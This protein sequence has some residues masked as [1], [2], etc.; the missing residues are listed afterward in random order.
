MGC[1][2]SAK[3]SFWSWSVFLPVASHISP[4]V[5]LAILIGLVWQRAFLMS[6][7]TVA[8]EL[9][10]IKRTTFLIRRMKRESA[11]H[12]N[13]LQDISRQTQTETNSKARFRMAVAALDDMINWVHSGGRV[14]IYD[15]TNS[16]E[17]RNTPLSR[18]FFIVSF[19]LFLR[20]NS[21][22]VF[23]RNEGSLCFRAAAK[24]GLK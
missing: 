1:S 14:A 10:H 16:T 20:D 4:R 15:G 12:C 23:Y 18:F 9:V 2:F 8:P 11:S 24:R 21:H 3:N 6:E 22:T 17:V 7:A 19:S 5:F 13:Y